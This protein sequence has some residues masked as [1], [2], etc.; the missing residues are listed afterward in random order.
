M[1]YPTIAYITT[2]ALT[3]LLTY[4]VFIRTLAMY[5]S[6]IAFFII[7]LISIISINY[8]YK[9]VQCQLFTWIRIDEL[10]PDLHKMSLLAAIKRKPVVIYIHAVLASIY[11]LCLYVNLTSVQNAF[12]FI[13]YGVLGRMLQVPLSEYFLQEHIKN[14]KLYYFG[15]LISAIGTL[16]YQIY[17]KTYDYGISFSTWDL[18]T[19]IIY[20]MG[21]SVNSIL[22]KYGTVPD[23]I[24]NDNYISVKQATIITLI[25]EAFIGLVVVVV[26]VVNSKISMRNLIPSAHQL[27]A[28]LV[29]GTVVPL[30]YTLSAN[31][32]NHIDHV[33]A[34][35]AD[36]IRIGLGAVLAS[37]IM[38]IS[39]D[40]E[41]LWMHFEYKVTGIGLV[42]TGTFIAFWGNP[43]WNK[44][45]VK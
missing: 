3:M 13:L 21:S 31:I 2:T 9:P 17:S 41:S 11:F 1:T 7:S 16:Y 38:Y 4:T 5:N 27:S 34:R 37:V 23:H 29:L 44:R 35:A 8:F 42:M 26:M 15:I 6:Y 39:G 36:G 25:I 28:I 45:I 10:K 18:A 12:L 40:F 24:G 19:A 20:L 32:V 14:R 43:V 22:F 30:L 33:V